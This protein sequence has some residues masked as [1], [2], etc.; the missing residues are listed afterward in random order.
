MVQF[1]RYKEDTFTGNVLSGPVTPS[2]AGSPKHPSRHVS[3]LNY[4]YSSLAATLKPRHFF[5]VVF[6][7]GL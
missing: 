5:V 7:G 2:R 4:W 1:R 3:N 6:V